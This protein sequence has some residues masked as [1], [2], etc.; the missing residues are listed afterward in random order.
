[1]PFVIPLFIPHEGCPHDCVFCNQHKIS[2]Q[3]KPLSSDDVGAEITTWLQWYRPEKNNE[4]QVAFYGGSFTGLPLQ[5]QQLLLLAVKGFIDKG[6]V[7]S[8]RL[9][10]RPDYISRDIVDF[11]AANHV[12]VVE[13]GVQSL[14]DTVLAQAHRGHRAYH[15]H[16][17]MDLL[18]EKDFQTGIQLMLGL[19]GDSFPSLRQTLEQVRRLQPD[20][21]RI[22]PV[23]VVKGSALERQYQQGKYTP[24]TL[25][26]AVI[27][28][29][30]MKK[31]FDETGVRVVRMGLQPGVTLEQ[32]LVAGPYHPA[33]G[34]LVQSRLMLNATR[35]ILQGVKE[36]EPV[37]LIISPRDIS[38]FKGQ[39]SSNMKRLASLNLQDLFTLKT[40]PAQKRQT[41]RKQYA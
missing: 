36:G 25:E 30:Y 8:I 33:F 24:L 21:V 6:I 23:L 12:K 16:E 1:M 11:L 41:I 17:A 22:Y 2:G 32:S 27:L 13:L 4:V 26:R 39:H 18:R 37:E 20:F 3:E 34:Q 40:D 29:A 19:P 28:C 9:S 31:Y 15:V 7:Q 14:N 5:R 38:I 10:T 35:K